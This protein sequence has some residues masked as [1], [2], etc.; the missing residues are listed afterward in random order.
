LFVQV[1]GVGSNHVKKR[2]M[3]GGPLCKEGDDLE[4]IKTGGNK[5]RR[6]RHYQSSPMDVEELLID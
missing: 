3:I 2:G 1:I 6:P 4:V 5:I